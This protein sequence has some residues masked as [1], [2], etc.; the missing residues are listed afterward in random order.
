MKTINSILRFD[1]RPWLDKNNKPEDYYSPEL[2]S[3]PSIQ[4]KFTPHY[5]TDFSIPAFSIK[6]KYYQRLIDNSITDFLNGIMS[7]TE[8]GSDNLI[9]YK[10]KNA[11]GKIKSLMTEI[12]DL[13]ILKD[14]DLNL[15]T[16][17]HSN[18]NTDRLHKEVTYIFQYMLTALIK[19]YLEIQQHFFTHIHKDELLDI[20]EIYSRILNKPA[21]DNIFIKQVQTIQIEHIETIK[22]QP[23]ETEPNYAIQYAQDKYNVF[24]EKVSPY[25]FMELPKYNA[26]N[27][28]AQN[29]LTKEIIENPVHYSVAMLNF[30]G[31]LDYLKKTYSLSK[32]KTYKHI[33]QALKTDERTVKGNCLVLNPNSKE[34]RYKY[35]ADEYSKKVEQD[36]NNILAGKPLK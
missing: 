5:N 19:C 20:P 36:Y 2:R 11:K 12:S 16:S 13:I 14:Y 4:E 31:Y 3:T 30:L 25:R 21:P 17:K 27:Q 28:T 26:L 35:Q 15:I 7:E 29:R 9:A 6:I 24:M 1:L 34:D 23:E 8:N 22:S 10:L 18:F 32:E 33:S